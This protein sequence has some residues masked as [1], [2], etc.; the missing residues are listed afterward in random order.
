MLHFPNRPFIG[1]F[2][3]GTL[4]LVDKIE[5]FIRKYYRNQLIRGGILGLGGSLAVFLSAALLEYVGQ[6]GQMPRAILFFGSLGGI[7]GWLTWLIAGPVLGLFRLGKRLSHEEAAKIIGKH[8]PDIQDALLNTLQLEKMNRQASQKNELIEAAIAQRTEQLRPIPFQQAIDFSINRRYLKYALIPLGLL[9]LILIGKPEAITGSTQRLVGFNKTFKPDVGFELNIV[10][11]DMEV[12]ENEDFTLSVEAAGRIVPEVVYLRNGENTYRM[13]PDGKGKFKYTFRSP[14]EDQVFQLQAD[15]YVS[16]PVYLRVVPRPSVL[17]LEMDLDFPDYLGLGK[18]TLANRGDLTVP[19]GTKI[20]WRIKARKTEKIHL[21]FQDSTHI[22]SGEKDL[23]SFERKIRAEMPYQLAPAN[24]FAGSPDSQSYVIRVIQDQFPS[25]QVQEWRDSLLP[26]RIYFQGKA[27]DDYGLK[28]LVFRFAKG[29]AEEIPASK[30]FQ[31]ANLSLPMG[32]APAQRFNHMLDADVLSLLP[33]E[34]VWYYFEVW[35]NDG[36]RGSKSTKTQMQALRLPTKEEI[37]AMRQE[38]QASVQSGL[39]ESLKEA[40]EIQE[41][42]ETLRREMLQSQDINWNQKEKLQDL[43]SRQKEMEQ[44]LEQTRLQQQQNNVRDERLSKEEQEI[45]D[46][47]KKLEELLENIR[48]QDLEKMLKEMEKAMER[49]DRQKMQELMDKMQ[50]S[51]EDLSKELDRS[52]ELY[53]QLALEQ[54]LRDLKDA[55]ENLAQEQERL[56]KD[57]RLSPEEKARRQ[58]ELNKQFEALK[59]EMQKAEEQNKGL[60]RPRDLPS[61]EEKAKETEAQMQQAQEQLQQQ[62]EQK[63]RSAQQKAAQ[64]MREMAK[65]MEAALE[66]EGQQEEDMEALR[67]LLE[68][69]V[70]LSLNQEQIMESLKS[71]QRTDPRVREVARSQRKLVEDAKVVEDSLE[72]LAKRVLEIE[73]IITKEMRDLRRDMQSS[74]EFLGERQIPP[75][76]QRQ[77]GAMTAANNL[78]LMLSEVLDQMREQQKQQQQGQ[79]SPSGSCKKP[80]SASGS[81]MQ[82]LLQR[83]MGVEKRMQEIMEK[84][85]QQQAEKQQGREPGKKPGDKPGEQN[86]QGKPGGQGEGGSGQQG[87][88]N[89]QMS[90]DLARLAAEQE[91]IRRE[92]QGMMQQLNESGR[93]MAGE[94]MQKM[95]ENETDIL[96][97]RITAETLRR[98][99]DITRRMMESDK[100]QRE[101]EQDEKRQ[102]NENRRVFDLQQE[103]LEDYFRA[104]A[105]E[106]EWLRTVSPALK[107]YYKTKV[108]QYF[109]TY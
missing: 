93:K 78:A 71:Y 53:K 2:L 58:A 88:N 92:L 19:E 48:S 106:Q 98:Q 102:A 28:R 32:A 5:V 62:K 103:K 4:Q 18:Q 109:N 21:I 27:E 40:Q 57:T 100:A 30:A 24:R 51:N 3:M 10:N 86:G 12:L 67:Q 79:G 56:E 41:A 76:V 33:G 8:F 54:Q 39:Q 42:L 84:M 108:S 9:G 38:G 52:L 22:L 1:I 105:R 20:K 95:E 25:I 81:S 72:A 16:D 89:G 36:V 44:R 26:G 61:Q 85:R 14:R 7:L 15:A 107:P 69:L 65:Q 94:I 68:N 80:G 104:K 63:A 66:Q 96:N 82:S 29:Q 64:N 99:Q 31:S 46:K 47:Q 37:R 75:A 90:Q 70:R 35:D 91:Q 13:E 87:G 34:T 43:L 55:L 83:Q 23:F 50:M 60:S 74:I 6:F 77:Q 17:H 11:P 97:R 49:M 101:Q 73:S 45:L 59:Q